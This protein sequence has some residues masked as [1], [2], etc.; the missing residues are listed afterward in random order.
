[1]R[2]KQLFMQTQMQGRK[3]Q[4]LLLFNED[5]K[6]RMENES[7]RDM[8]MMINNERDHSLFERDN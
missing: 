3:G 1:M 5:N 8:I 4:A 2:C 6:Q 7:E